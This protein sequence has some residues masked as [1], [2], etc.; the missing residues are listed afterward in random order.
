[1]GT[2]CPTSL[3]RH[4]PPPS[5]PARPACKPVPQIGHVTFF[6]NGNRSGYID[7]KLELF[8]EVGGR[9]LAM[10]NCVT[11]STDPVGLRGSRPAWR[12]FALGPAAAT[13]SGMLC[14]GEKCGAAAEGHTVLPKAPK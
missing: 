2:L 8:K 10:I 9:V 1:M 6:W 14:A 4:P 11:N 13:S 5:L 7:P 12:G 3:R